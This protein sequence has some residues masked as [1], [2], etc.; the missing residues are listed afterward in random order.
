MGMGTR[1]SKILTGCVFT[2]VSRLHTS[3][4]TILLLSIHLVTNRVGRAFV[5]LFA[6]TN[7]YLVMFL[8]PKLFILFPKV[9]Y[10]V[11]DRLVRPNLGGTL[12]VSWSD[13][14]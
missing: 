5:L 3:F 13:S 1:S 14:L 11:T 6:V 4:P 9:L 2:I 7:T 8:I 10:N 12:T